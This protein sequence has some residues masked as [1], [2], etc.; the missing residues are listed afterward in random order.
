MRFD[1]IRLATEK[2]V[3]LVT[4]IGGCEEKCSVL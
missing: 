1:R 3:F 2:E 4:E